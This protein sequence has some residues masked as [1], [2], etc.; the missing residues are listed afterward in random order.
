M[1]FETKESGIRCTTK[2]CKV[3]VVTATMPAKSLETLRSFLDYPHFQPCR[4][5]LHALYIVAT[6]CIYFIC[7]GFNS[8]LGLACV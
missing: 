5:G 8:W 7:I 2:G 3:D 6:L 1:N 4:L